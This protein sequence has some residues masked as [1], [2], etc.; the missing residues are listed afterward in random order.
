MPG[1]LAALFLVP[2]LVVGSWRLVLM[3]SSATATIIYALALWH[4]RRSTALT[5]LGVLNR[6]FL[7]GLIAGPVSTAL[8]I[9]L[10]GWLVSGPGDAMVLLFHSA[11]TIAWATLYACVTAPLV[12]V[13]A[14]FILFRAER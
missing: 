2:P 3:A 5:R 1:F 4:A 12:G 14:A 11:S 6:F 8:L 13:A 7:A 9:M 10:T